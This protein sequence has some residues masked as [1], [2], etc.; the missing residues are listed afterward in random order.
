M[1]I[2]IEPRLARIA[3]V[4]EVNVMGSDYSLRIWLD[5]GKMARYGLVPSDITAVLD[6]QNL[7]APTGTLGTESENTFQ[8][9]LKYRGRYEFEQDYE[10]MV[11]KSLPGGEELKLKDVATIELG[12]RT[13]TYIGEVNG[14]PGSNCMI[15][16]TSGSNANEIIEE[17]DKVV[18]DIRETL[19]K[20]MEIADL[21]STKDFLDA[22]IKNVIKTL[23]EAIVLVILVVYVFLQSFRSTFIPAV[24]IIVSLIGTFAFLAVAGFSLNMLTLFALVLVIGTVVDDAIVVVEAVQAKFDEGYKSP[25]LATIDAMSNITSALVTTT[26]VFMAVFIPV[27]FMG[28]RPVRSISQF[29][30]T[31]AVA[32]RYFPA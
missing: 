8:Y 2:N 7:E 22:S 26:F 24:S 27:S 6:E 12:S 18:E 32:G 29:G 23:I 4:G 28:V 1:K 16:Q 30:L 20:G 14:H 13:Y 5:P 9:V 17:I 21:M 15:A 19:P 31:M 3:G 25:Y 10:N 11:I